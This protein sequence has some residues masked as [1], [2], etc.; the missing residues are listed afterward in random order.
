MLWIGLSFVTGTICWFQATIGL[1]CPG[2]GS[3]RAA[4]ALFQ[5]HFA[6]AFFWH[7]LIIVSLVL[8]PYLVI[9]KVFLR[10][11]PMRSIETKILIGVGIGYMIVFV[12][13]MI[14]FFPHTPPMVMHDDAVIR[15]FIR[16]AAYVFYA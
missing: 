16:L 6:E 5:G 13:R 2:C 4:L 12:V 8:L 3:T 15:Q 9:R 14:L 10:R 7:P 1:P 11:K